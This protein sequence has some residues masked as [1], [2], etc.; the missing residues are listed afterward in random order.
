LTPWAVNQS[1]ARRRAAARPLTRD[2]DPLLD[3]ASG[4]P[5][6]NRYSSWLEWSGLRA[7]ESIWLNLRQ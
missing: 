4:S 3:L 1:A 2:H 7:V 5:V 6:V